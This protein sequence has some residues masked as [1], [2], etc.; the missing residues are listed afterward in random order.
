MFSWAKIYFDI[1][2]KYFSNYHFSVR[3]KMLRDIKVK[4]KYFVN[5]GRLKALSYPSGFES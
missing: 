2:K 1:F 4:K 5:Y 3:T